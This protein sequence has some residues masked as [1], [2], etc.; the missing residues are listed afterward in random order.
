[1]GDEAQLVSNLRGFK[2]RVHGSVEEWRGRLEDFLERSMGATGGRPT[3]SSDIKELCDLFLKTDFLLPSFFS[4]NIDIET[5][6]Y[7]AEF[8]RE[9]LCSLDGYRKF[10]GITGFWYMLSNPEAIR[11]DAKGRKDLQCKIGEF[12]ND[13]RRQC[14][15]YPNSNIGPT[16]IIHGYLLGWIFEYPA[17]ATLLLM[18][19]ASNYEERVHH[20]LDFD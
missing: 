2:L 18:T 8:Y 19:V 15:Y 6:E 3:S 10:L 11:L 12:L 1:M 5:T 17:D 13:S 16:N 7:H 4:N 20:K 9:L 14:N